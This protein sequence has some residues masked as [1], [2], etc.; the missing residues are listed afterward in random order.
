MPVGDKQNLITKIV[1][2]VLGE[3]AQTKKK[4]DWLINKHLSEYFQQ[5]YLNIEN[6]FE[7][8]KGDNFQNQAKQTVK[9]QCD[10]YFGGNYNFIFEFDEYQHFS[11]SRLKTFDY[12]PKDIKLNFDLD[13]WKALCVIYA[14]KAD[15]YRAQKK[16]R[17]FN[18]IDGRTSQRAYLDCFRDFLPELH[19]YNPTLRISAFE[20]EQ[21]TTE[22]KTAYKIIEK[23][24]D[25]KF[26]L[27]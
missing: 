16:T 9:L 15:K 21:I 19:G 2:K 4:F 1:S 10:A 12:Y 13:E 5:Y 20:V 22:D 23:L 26:S 3:S 25:N 24:L 17:D 14:D 11:S 6:I 18:F 7:V 8:L 27:S